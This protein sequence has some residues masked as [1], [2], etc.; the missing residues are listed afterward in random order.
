MYY[1]FELVLKG[2]RFF[3]NEKFLRFWLKCNTFKSR[4]SGELLS[5]PRVFRRIAEVS[6]EFGYRVEI[7]KNNI[8]EI[9]LQVNSTCFPFL[10]DLGCRGNQC[11]NFFFYNWFKKGSGFREKGYP[12]SQKP[13]EKPQAKSETLEVF[14]SFNSTF[15]QWWMI[16]KICK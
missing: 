11:A 12:P 14:F 6:F 9:I 5:H 1:G 2:I 8:K 13:K 7:I 16:C 15:E 10:G 4:L 3:C